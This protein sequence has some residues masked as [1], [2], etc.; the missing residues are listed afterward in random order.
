[1]ASVRNTP[2]I[3]PISKLYRKLLRTANTFLGNLA[4]YWNYAVS[5]FGSKRGCI[6]PDW[7]K[8]TFLLGYC[9]QKIAYF[10]T[11]CFFWNP[12]STTCTESFV[13]S[14]IDGLFQMIINRGNFG[15]VLHTQQVHSY[16]TCAWQPRAGMYGWRQ[17]V[18]QHILEHMIILLY[19]LTI[20]YRQSIYGVLYEVYSVVHLTK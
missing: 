2:V 19:I 7:G 6:F 14:K 12:D 17:A 20:L 9:W 18:V 13:Q 11:K 5:W 8:L 1:M 3:Q 4:S 15:I 10:A 16:T